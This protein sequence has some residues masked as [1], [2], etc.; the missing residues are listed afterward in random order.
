MDFKRHNT[1]CFKRLTHTD[2]TLKFEVKNFLQTKTDLTTPWFIQT[3]VLLALAIL[4]ILWSEDLRSTQELTIN[5][6][7]LAVL[8][9]QKPTLA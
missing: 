6:Q 7:E 3:L 2:T 8:E 9:W 1:H 4:E 5:M